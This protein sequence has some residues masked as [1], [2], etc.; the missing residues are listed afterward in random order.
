M[1]VELGAQMLP[2]DH[3]LAHRLVQE[4]GIPTLRRPP[5]PE[6]SLVSLRGRTRTLKQIRRAR[7][8]RPFHY[9]VSTRL[10]RKGPSGIMRKAL[11]E[12]SRHQADAAAPAD[13]P[14]DARL[15]D[16]LSEEEIQFLC[17]RTAY[18]F[19]REPLDAR[20]MFDWVARELFENHREMLQL[21]TGMSAVIEA[22]S[23][24]IQRLG[25]RISTRQ[26]LAGIRTN[27]AAPV[28]L[29]ISDSADRLRTVRAKRVVLA[30]PRDAIAGIEGFA[31]RPAVRQ[32]LDSVRAWP[33]VRGA[34]VYPSAWWLDLGFTTAH[35]ST[36]LP[37][38]WLD[39]VGAGS[40]G[41]NGPSALTF[42]ADGT[43]GDYWRN[44][45]APLPT[46]KWL[47]ASHPFTVE[48]HRMVATLY[49]PFLRKPLPS[50]IEA[51]T[52]DWQNDPFGGA[53]HLWNL[54]ARPA[55]A[56]RLARQPVADE[57]IH[58]C[59]EAWSARHAWIEG[60]L[61]SV[62]QTVALLAGR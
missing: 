13:G 12:R 30:L 38:G 14:F 61:E 53:F 35:T 15:L 1:P 57:P 9:G 40:P 3:L 19:W 25:G 36:D 49:E 34:I 50:P 2:S 33:I 62:E 10:Q 46:G 7:F 39:H 4:L 41:H 28:V 55:E 51:I 44:R 6:C 59:G 58:I 43:R 26:R 18:S 47:N 56:M 16:V 60:A 29:R 31:E 42:Y 48:L 21:P 20:A 54:N 32:L 22:L 45:F 23:A 24:E 27:G 17:D 37:L 5:E 52:T 8:F 11:A